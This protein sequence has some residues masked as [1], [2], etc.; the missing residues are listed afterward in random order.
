MRW[1]RWVWV[2]FPVLLLTACPPDGEGW[3]YRPA[4]RKD[5]REQTRNLNAC[6]EGERLKSVCRD[7]SVDPRKCPKQCRPIK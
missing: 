6:P 4:I 5:Y 7:A 2:I 1:L 3:D